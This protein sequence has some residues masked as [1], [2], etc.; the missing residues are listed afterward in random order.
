MM[1]CYGGDRE[2]ELDPWLLSCVCLS[3]SSA[4]LF[5]KGYIVER[6]SPF[7]TLPPSL[8]GGYS[9]PILSTLPSL[10][11]SGMNVTLQCGS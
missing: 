9:E 1:V 5:Y 2:L 11:T 6:V 8:L 4:Y 10:V 3:I 7:T